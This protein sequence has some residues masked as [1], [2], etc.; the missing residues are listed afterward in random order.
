ML[1]MLFSHGQEAAAQQK[2]VQRE[3]TIP[4]KPIG[5]EAASQQEP[6]LREAAK[7]QKTSGQ[8]QGD[9]RK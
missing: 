1:M 6:V 4:L 7:Q 8:I 3:A 2:P 5:R 9:K